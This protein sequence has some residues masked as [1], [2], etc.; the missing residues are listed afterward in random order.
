MDEIRK[1]G[2]RFRLWLQG[3]KSFLH[4]PPSVNQKGVRETTKIRWHGTGIL[5]DKYQSSVEMPFLFNTSEHDMPA[6]ED[7]ESIPFWETIVGLHSLPPLIQAPGVIDEKYL[8]GVMGWLIR[9]LWAE[10]CSTAPVPGITI[11]PLGF[12]YSGT[13]GLY[14]IVPDGRRVFI[15]TSPDKLIKKA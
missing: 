5:T 8:V 10:A 6:T 1:D 3:E 2:H 9:G 12:E 15:S 13:S 14:A 7:L 4:V 11:C